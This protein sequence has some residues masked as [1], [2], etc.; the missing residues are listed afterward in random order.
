M[1]QDGL[2]GSELIHRRAD[3]G[4]G[5]TPQQAIQVI[6][7]AFTLRMIWRMSQ[8]HDGARGAELSSPNGV[9]MR[10]RKQKIAVIAVFT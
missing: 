7:H 1:S 8:E 4:V 6:K 9:R 10:G 5:C 2:H 3:K